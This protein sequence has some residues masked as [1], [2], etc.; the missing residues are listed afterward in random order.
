MGVDNWL[1]WSF[2]HKVSA[3]LEFGYADTAIWFWYWCLCLDNG[4]SSILITIQTVSGTYY[5]PLL[6]TFPNPYHMVLN[7]ISSNKPLR[8]YS[9]R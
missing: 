1:P 8:E 9:P 7:L 3:E 6:C 4:Y 5:L 2:F